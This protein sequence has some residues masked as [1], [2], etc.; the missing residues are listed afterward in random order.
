MSLKKNEIYV[1]DTLRQHTV[2]ERDGYE[3]LTDETSS[4]KV[5]EETSLLERY[6]FRST[7]IIYS[8]RC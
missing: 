5:K 4:V 6:C 7:R 1:E 3:R 8:H 2:K